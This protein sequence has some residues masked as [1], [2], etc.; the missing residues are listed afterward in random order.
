M[1]ST[2]PSPPASKL[3][4]CETALDA[5]GHTPLVRLNKVVDG[6]A[7]LVLGKV[8]YV[9]PG[10]SVKDR[11]AVAMLDAAERQGLL[12]PGGTIVEPTSGNTG[13]RLG[14]GR[15][16]SRISLH[17]RDARQNVER[18]DRPAAR[19]RC[20]RRDH[21]DQR[22][23]RF[24]GVVLRRRQPPGIGDTRRVS[25]QSI[26]QS[27]QSGSALPFDRSR[28][29]GADRWSDH[30]FRRRHR[31][32]RNDFR[33]RPVFE[34][35]ESGDPRRRRGSRRIDLFRRYSALV[36]RRR[37]R[38]ELLA[39]NGGFTGD[40]RDGARLRSRFI[41]DGA[42]DRTRGGLTRRRFFGNRGC[43][44]GAACQ[45]AAVRGDRRRHPAR[46]GPRLHV[47]DFQRRLDDRQ[48]FSG[49]CKAARHGRRT[50]CAARRRCRRCSPCSRTIPSRR[51]SICCASTR[52]RRFP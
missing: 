23:P 30:A 36:R 34:G 45:D 6:A 31:N 49:R 44:G 1:A 52:S 25:A 47:E 35:K 3:T 13:Y 7:C 24:T 9:N 2:A 14:D 28:D 48:R 29:L 37:H 16:D 21:P 10:G 40:R 22:S 43:R 46:L 41:F 20:G 50:F 8:E 5:I 33:H 32:R 27:F 51:R 19:L 26:S 38:H 17:L 15:R 42:P 39:R 12:K 11:P 4:Y 18:K